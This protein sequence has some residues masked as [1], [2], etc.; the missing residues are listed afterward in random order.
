MARGQGPADGTQVALYS[1]GLFTSPTI[2][3]S[4]AF[5]SCKRS[6]NDRSPGD[7]GSTSL[8]KDLVELHEHV[9]EVAGIQVHIMRGVQGTL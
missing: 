9:K 5:F 1:V 8:T 4:H 2:I 3:P 6:P 7:M